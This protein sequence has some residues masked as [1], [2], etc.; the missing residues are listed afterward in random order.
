MTYFRIK[1]REKRPQ[2]VLTIPMT[3]G[4]TPDTH[5]QMCMPDL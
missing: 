4:D 3:K 1:S 2:I 5:S